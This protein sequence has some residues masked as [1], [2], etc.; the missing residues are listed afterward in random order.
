M[1]RVVP[2]HPLLPLP[3]GDFGG[4]TRWGGGLRIP[5]LAWVDFDRVCRVILW[6]WSLQRIEAFIPHEGN[7]TWEVEWMH[8]GRPFVLRGHPRGIL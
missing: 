8:H 6:F 3:L 2:M 5:S 4:L 1:G 7:R